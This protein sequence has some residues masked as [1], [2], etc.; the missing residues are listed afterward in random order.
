MLQFSLYKLA[1][2]EKTVPDLSA[3]ELQTLPAKVFGGVEGVS[4]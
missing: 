4:G 1:H 2:L 3:D